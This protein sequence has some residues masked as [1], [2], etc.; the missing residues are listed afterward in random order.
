MIQKIK[1]KSHR[2]RGERIFV[3]SFLLSLGIWSCLCP[4]SAPSTAGSST[5]GAVLPLEDL[6]KDFVRQS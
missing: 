4:S 3:F 6:V 1:K 5:L 2:D